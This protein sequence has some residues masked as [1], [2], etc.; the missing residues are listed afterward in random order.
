MPK[1]SPI[2]SNFNG[3]EISPLLYGRV[4]VP[5]YKESLAIC[6]NYLPLIQGPITRRPGSSFVFPVKSSS[7]VTRLIPFEF[8]TVQAYMI[9]FG[10]NYV[11]FFKNNGIITNSPKT[12]T[13]ITQ[14][15]PGVITSTSHGF[16]NGDHIVINAVSGM[17]ELDNREFTV[18]NSL[19]NSFTLVDNI[20]GV[21]VDTTSYTAYSSGGTAAKI[22]EVATLYATADIPTIK[23][24]QSD[25]VLYLT[26]PSYPPAKLIR[27]ADNDWTF[28]DSTFVGSATKS[29]TSAL[30][31]LTDGPYYPVNLTGTT[32]SGSKSSGAGH[33][34]VLTATSTTGINGSQGF[35]STDVGRL[36][37]IED[38]NASSAWTWFTITSVVSTTV[39]N[40]LGPTLTSAARTLTDTDQWRLGFW[41]ETD[42]FPAAVV[43][44]EDRLVFGGAGGDP[45]R[46]DGSNT[47]DYENFSPSVQ[48]TPGE[49]SDGTISDSCAYS[50]SLVSNDVNSILWETSDEQGLII[51]TTGGE[52]LVSSASSTSALSPTSVS[53]KKMTSYGS[54]NIQAVQSGK[55]SLFIQKG[56]RKLR[57]LNYYFDVN[58]FRAADLTQ[59]SEHISQTRFKFLAVQKT[60]QPI[61][62]G[63]RTDGVLLAM[64]YERDLDA[65]KVGWSRHVMGGTVSGGGSSVVESVAVIPSADGSSQ[66]V[67]I[68]VQRFING[69]VVRYVEY[70]T[71]LFDED[72]ELEDAFFVDSGLTY[73][74]TATGTVS[75]LNHLSGQTVAVLA[76]GSPLANRGVINGRVT[77]DV[78][79]T[80]SVITIG[81]PY[82]SDGQKLRNDAGA[83][84]G[85][86]MGKTRRTHRVGI[87]FLNTLGFLLGPDFDTL[88]Q[89][90]LDEVGDANFDNAQGLYT[91]IR[92]EIITTDYDFDNMFCWRQNQPLPGTI[93]GIYPQMVEQDR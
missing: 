29:V 14:A 69:S 39:V 46:F 28:N 47:S 79:T 23:Y 90:T 31:A 21:A 1:V 19:T 44:H 20:T 17:T 33:P 37:R 22:Y 16:A 80:A 45:T 75:G 54:E 89:I 34:M 63:I 24:T 83:A 77:L 74:G 91:G 66:D 52:W 59:I 49:F 58:G 76:D 78:G 73:S 43:F 50:F 8:S 48:Q 55:C 30:L 87:Q 2:Q 61:V 81:L 13:S 51:G 27:N 15:N 35:L 68:I 32:I 7:A 70:L 86:A 12:I 53:A 18:A 71:Q 62:W 38:S 67:W 4:D 25:D 92:S 5:R 40:T 56:G 10:N 36:I 9:E 93:L 72:T 3:G 65:L 84:D 60:P 6:K 85:T 57:E 26:H 42:G 88:D 11:R 41:S 82:N 64:T